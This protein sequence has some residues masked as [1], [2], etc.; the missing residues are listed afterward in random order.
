MKNFPHVPLIEKGQNPFSIKEGALDVAR[1]VRWIRKNAGV[2]GFDPDN[3]AV[4]GFSAGGI[5]AG[6]FLMHYDE[7]VTGDAL[8]PDYVPDELDKVPAHATAC[9]MIYA[10]YGRLSVGNMDPDWLHGFGAAGG[11]VETY[12]DWLENVWNA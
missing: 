8:D 5:Q 7:D 12:A 3:I 2:Y 9:G 11:W 1:A 4:M 6:E 10:F